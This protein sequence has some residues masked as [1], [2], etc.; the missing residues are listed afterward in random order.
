MCLFNL[1]VYFSFLLF[2]SGPCLGVQYDQGAWKP[3]TKVPGAPTRKVHDPKNV[4]GPRRQNVERIQDNLVVSENA[5]IRRKIVPSNPDK[6]DHNH[7]SHSKKENIINTNVDS[8]RVGQFFS[9]PHRPVKINLQQ[10][11]QRT[12]QGPPQS[13]IAPL[14]MVIDSVPS[15]LP[16]QSESFRQT[17]A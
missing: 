3:M 5:Q 10:S 7:M 14:C 6:N 15:T 1:F 8:D 4:R 2:N 17:H 16:Q 11:I 12:H 9:K 13:H